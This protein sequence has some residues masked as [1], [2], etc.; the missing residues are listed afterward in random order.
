MGEMLGIR[1][2]ILQAVAPLSRRTSSLIRSAREL[3][4]PSL[5]LA[6]AQ[7]LLITG[8]FLGFI[9][10]SALTTTF[11]Y[12]F[13]LAAGVGWVVRQA[14]TA[15]VVTFL[16]TAATLLTLGLIAAFLVREAIPVFR[17]AGLDLIWPF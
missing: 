2:T 16:M 3:D 1:T 13:L 14:L 17:Y 12:G 9:A 8:T 15:K 10:Q 11:L 4:R 5:L 6:T 7:I